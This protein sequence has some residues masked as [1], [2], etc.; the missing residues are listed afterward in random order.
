MAARGRRIT[1]LLGIGLSCMATGA[2][3]F[4]MGRQEAEHALW[5]AHND[6]QEARIDH[7]RT[8]VDDLWRWNKEAMEAVDALTSTQRA[9]WGRMVEYDG[10]LYDVEML[11]RLLRERTPWPPQNAPK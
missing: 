10:R 5:R 6:R 3:I 8:Q 11:V 2:V 7:L 9:Y 1:T 4:L